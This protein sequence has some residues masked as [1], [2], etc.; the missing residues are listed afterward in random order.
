MEADCLPRCARAGGRRAP[1]GR[2]PPSAGATSAVALPRSRRHCCPADARRPPLHRG[3]GA[4]PTYLPISGAARSV[5]KG[6]RPDPLWV[7]DGPS[8]PLPGWGRRTAL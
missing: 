4:A 3:R 2:S 1:D 7:D 6:R 5:V 8:A